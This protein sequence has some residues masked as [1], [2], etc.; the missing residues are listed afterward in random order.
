MG[1]LAAS[2]FAYRSFFGTSLDESWQ[3][4]SSRSVLE[5]LDSLARGGIFPRVYQVNKVRRLSR[6]CFPAKSRDTNVV[7]QR[8]ERAELVGCQRS[9]DT[10]AYALGVNVVHVF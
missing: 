5:C 9:R 1:E 4:F 8:N 7:C 2:A 6:L 10:S 3:H